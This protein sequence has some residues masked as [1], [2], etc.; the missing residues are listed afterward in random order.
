MIVI[1]AIPFFVAIIGLLMFALSKNSKVSQIGLALFTAAMVAVMIA[2]SK[3]TWT[4]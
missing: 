3:K 4:L 2:M 1:A